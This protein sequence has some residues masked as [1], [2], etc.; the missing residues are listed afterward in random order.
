MADSPQH[1]EVMDKFVQK[2]K[3]WT[4]NTNENCPILPV[5][6]G[7]SEGIAMKIAA[8]GFAALSTLDSGFYGK[9]MYF[10]TSAI[11]TAPYFSKYKDPAILICLTIPG[12]PYPVVEDYAT[13][14]SLTG[15]ALIPGYQ[16][17]YVLVNSSG[18]IPSKNEKDR[19]L[20]DELV[21]EQE[22]QVVPIFLVT[23][24]VTYDLEKIMNS[25]E[26][27]L[28]IFNTE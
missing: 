5:V 10:S 14:K 27:D 26:R 3:L 7:T 21:L 17:H 4:W 15:K 24:L 11:Y 23:L 9:G 28:P 1:Q 8:G 12:N 6:H 19:K 25:F 20:Y 16:S 18:S 22:A 13:E 2:S